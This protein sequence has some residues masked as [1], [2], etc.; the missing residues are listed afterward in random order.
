MIECLLSHGLP[1]LLD[2]QFIGIFMRELRN[3]VRHV[4][5]S[6]PDAICIPLVQ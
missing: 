3:T 2:I 5:K 4:K 6:R 1:K